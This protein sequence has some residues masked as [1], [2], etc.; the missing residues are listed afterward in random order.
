[1]VSDGAFIFHMCIYWDKTFSLE[2]RSRLTVKVKYQGHNLLAPLA[3]GQRA[4][5]MALCPLC[6]CPSVRPSVCL[7]VRR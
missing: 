2:P 5:V 1:M 3:K 6:I 4:I 7:W